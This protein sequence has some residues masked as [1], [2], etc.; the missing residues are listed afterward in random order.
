MNAE[1]VSLDSEADGT[2]M[3]MNQAEPTDTAVSPKAPS[4][5]NYPLSTI[6]CFFP[7]IFLS[8]I[9]CPLTTKIP[10]R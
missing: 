2:L 3:R 1:S 4:Y 9:R 8:P 10:E 6:H 7:Y 5:N